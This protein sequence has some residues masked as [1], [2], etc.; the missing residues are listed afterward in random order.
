[1]HLGNLELETYHCIPGKQS[2]NSRQRQPLFKK[3]QQQ[4]KEATREPRGKEWLPRPSQ[5]L[6]RDWR[7]AELPVPRETSSRCKYPPVG[8]CSCRR[9]CWEAGKRSGSAVAVGSA[10]LL[11]ECRRV[12]TGSRYH[13]SA[14][15]IFLVLSSEKREMP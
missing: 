4:D 14:V 7:A 8:H 10:E 2:H 5:K 12:G 6:H 3:R 9:G 11:Q 15:Q 13:Q 1:M